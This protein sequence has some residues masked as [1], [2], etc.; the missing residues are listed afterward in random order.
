MEDHVQPLAEE[1][2]GDASQGSSLATST[3]STTT[4][5]QESPAISR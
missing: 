1:V 4:E 3:E 2:V 5:S